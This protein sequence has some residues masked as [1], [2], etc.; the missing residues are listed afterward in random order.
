MPMRS[1][2]GRPRGEFGPVDESALPG[3]SGDDGM[4]D[5]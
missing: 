4:K 2:L 1:R 5:T 3:A